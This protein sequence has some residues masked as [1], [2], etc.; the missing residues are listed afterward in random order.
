MNSRQER[1][2]ALLIVVF[3][4][5]VAVGGSVFG[6]SSFQ[7]GITQRVTTTNQLTKTLTSISFTTLQSP[8]ELIQYCFSPGGNC[9]NI[10]IYW[11]QRAN[12]SIHV[13]IY[14]FTLNAI[15]E[16]LILARSRGVD[17]KVVME[18]ENALGLGSE[19]Q[20]LKNAGIDI[21]LD[22]NPSEMHNKVAIIDGR[23]IITGSFNWSRNANT[24][25]NEN[26]VVLDSEAWAAAYEA[27]FQIIYK[28]ASA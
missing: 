16:A 7:P 24:N 20:N 22:T 1:P 5:G 4:V 14:S 2:W 23:I 11:V 8:E 25:N 6:L 18:R 26:L 3:L 12:K 9:A 28:A 13:L 17:V 19:F 27:E 21:R 15:A 10:I